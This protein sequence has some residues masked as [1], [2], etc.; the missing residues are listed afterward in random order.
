MPLFKELVMKILKL[1]LLSISTIGAMS[2]CHS[3][4]NG[5]PINSQSVS[6]S[7]IVNELSIQLDDVVKFDND[8]KVEIIN[9]L[10]LLSSKLDEA[11]KKKLYF[12]YANAIY[13]DEFGNSPE[14]LMAI[15][16]SISFI[17]I[18]DPYTQ[19]LIAKS[20]QDG[21]FGNNSEIIKTLANSLSEM[22][23]IDEDT[24]NALIIA[25][26]NGVFGSDR[27]IWRLVMRNWTL[28]HDIDMKWSWLL[29]S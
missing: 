21:K 17:N 10:V 24:Q 18:T 22:V 29:D 4:S 14:V 11:Q 8:S 13:F 19:Y 7:N 20:V 25:F 3:G 15:A 1:L 28:S 27:S 26:N 6:K 2:S 9:K 12:Q 5:V 16:K 23:V